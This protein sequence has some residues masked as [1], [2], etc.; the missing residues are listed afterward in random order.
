MET[1][2]WQATT[3]YYFCLSIGVAFNDAATTSLALLLFFL[4]PSTTQTQLIPG[5][6]QIFQT[7][8]EI[9]KTQKHLTRNGYYE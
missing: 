1:L 2:F 7:Q 4:I 8:L 9:Y 3:L 5:M 6:K